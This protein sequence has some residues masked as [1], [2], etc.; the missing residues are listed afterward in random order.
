MKKNIVFWLG[1]FLLLFI[2]SYAQ[3]IIDGYPVANFGLTVNVGADGNFFG[4]VL[5][6]TGNLGEWLKIKGSLQFFIRKNETIHYFAD[7]EEKKIVRHFPFVQGDYVGNPL[8]QSN[9]KTQVFCPL[10]IEDAKTS[11]LPVIM[12]EMKFINTSAKKNKFDLIIED[13]SLK[14]EHTKTVPQSVVQLENLSG[15]MFHAENFAIYCNEQINYKNEQIS[16]PIELQP[17][18]QLTLR[19][20]ISFYDAEW[21]SAVDFSS[22]GQIADYTHLKWDS[23]LHKTQQFE[24]LIPKT[25]D[26]EIDEY[27]RWYMVPAVSLTRITKNNE[28]LTMGY[29]ELNQRDSYWTSWLHLVFYRDLEKQMIEES[30]NWQQLSGKIPTTILPRIE[31][32][33]DLDINAFFILRAWR[34][35]QYHHDKE[36]L[37]AWWTSLQKAMDW[38]IS[39][40]IHGDG[41]PAQNSFWGDWKDVQGIQGRLYSPFSAMTYLAALDRMVQASYELGDWPA[42]EKYKTAFEKA[43]CFLNKPVEEG[44]LWNGH[45]YC[46]RWQNGEVTQQLLQDQMIGVLFN[47]VPKEYANKIVEAL[48]TQSLTKWGIAETTPYYPADWGYEPATY[49]NG[50]VWPWL[51]FMDCWARLKMGRT[52]EAITL[53]KTVA[54][55][56][57]IDSGDFS[58][59]EHINSMTGENLG[60][61]IQGWNAGLFGLVYFGLKGIP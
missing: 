12:L 19:L 20:A 58:P 41:L 52:D 60:F 17:K 8:I 36:A 4:N 18:Q 14:I 3:Q 42:A 59:N 46:Q 33:D 53:I 23:L 30:I 55:A 40:D 44:G 48:N 26:T 34:Y 57:L 2:K 1:C 28:T 31:R 49:H 13:D 21:Y 24:N 9:I 11:S 32:N 22:A 25:G 7:F 29:C 47:V 50:G 35:F 38:L 6:N 45:F 15:Y 51:S 16:I 27:L 56:D 54:R 10:G 5:Q 39:R 43:Y 37:L 61:I